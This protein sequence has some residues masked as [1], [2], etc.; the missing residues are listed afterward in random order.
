MAML[1]CRVSKKVM[2]ELKYLKKVIKKNDVLPEDFKKSCKNVKRLIQSIIEREVKA[3]TWRYD[4]SAR[5][6]RV[7]KIKKLKKMKKQEIAVQEK[8]KKK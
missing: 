8:K 5:E 7:Q 6:K 4:N 1:K 2:K 3:W